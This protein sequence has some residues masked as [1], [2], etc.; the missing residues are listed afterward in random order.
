[1]GAATSRLDEKGTPHISIPGHG[2]IQG[3]SVVDLTTGKVRAHR[4]TGVPY[5]VA[6]VEE[7]RWR[8][9]CPLPDS[10]RYDSNGA[11]YTTFGNICPQPGNHALS[12][13]P[14]P[15]VPTQRTYS[16]DCLLFNIWVPAG[17]PPLS[18]FP[19]LFFIHGGWLQTG[20]PH[21]E[22][23]QEPSD[24]IAPVEEGGAGLQ[25]IVICP[26]YRLNVFGFLCSKG[27]PEGERGN[28]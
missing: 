12:I 21:H 25:A 7:R 18:G 15:P 6:P 4:Y 20:H 13:N 14:S 16:E 2:S 17:E 19:V 23:D 9:P 8:K 26:G 3:T 1:M 5:A 22:I 24:L 10:Y 27:M 11:K 28:L